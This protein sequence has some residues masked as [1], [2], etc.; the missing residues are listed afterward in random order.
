ML[1]CLVKLCLL[2]EV[3]FDSLLLFM[4]TP[5]EVDY[6][7][8]HAMMQI[9][10]NNTVYLSSFDIWNKILDGSDLLIKPQTRL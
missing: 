2:I 9:R 7:S 5:R 8:N 10:F 3:V 1:P 4:I 6:I